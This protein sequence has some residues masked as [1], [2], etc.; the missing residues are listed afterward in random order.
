MQKRSVGD[1]SESVVTP[2]WKLRNN[3]SHS[4]HIAVHALIPL[5]KYDTDV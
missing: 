3:S 2:Y 5:A 1:R 4:R